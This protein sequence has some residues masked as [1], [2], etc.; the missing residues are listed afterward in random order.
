MTISCSK[1][2]DIILTEPTVSELLVGKWKLI[3]T[4]TFLGEVPQN[5]PTSPDYASI[6][7]FKLGDKLITNDPDYGD[8]TINGELQFIY[9]DIIGISESPIQSYT[10]TWPFGWTEFEVSMYMYV[11]PLDFPKSI[12]IKE[13][14]NDSLTLIFHYFWFD[15]LLYYERY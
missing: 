15:A 10:D 5:E 13:I 7:E 8:Y 9:G 6:I 11:D 12:D 4:Q 3:Q 2:D 14:S 1:S